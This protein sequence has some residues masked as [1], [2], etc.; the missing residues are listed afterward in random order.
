M[1]AT[2]ADISLNMAVH[3]KSNT[4]RTNLTPPLAEIPLDVIAAAVRL[5]DEGNDNNATR[6]VDI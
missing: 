4:T 5:G 1:S 2:A 3:N 6:L